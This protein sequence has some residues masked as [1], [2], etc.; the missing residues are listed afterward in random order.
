M[1][2]LSYRDGKGMAKIHASARYS[3][4]NTIMN[5][6][7]II[8]TITIITTIAIIRIVTIM[9]EFLLSLIGCV[10]GQGV[11]P[12]SMSGTFKALKTISE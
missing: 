3:L 7:R 5:I 9:K 10:V 8:T 1:A 4:S 2:L 6:I 11:E 12:P